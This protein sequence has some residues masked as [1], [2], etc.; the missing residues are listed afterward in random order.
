MNVVAPTLDDVFTKLGAFVA[1]I[2]PDDTAVIRGLVNR[3]SLPAA[4]TGFVAMTAI[5]QNRLRTNIDTY[6]DNGPEP[7]DPDD[8]GERNQTMGTQLTIQLDCYGADSGN[9]AAMLATLLRSEIGCDALAPVAQPLFVDGPHMAPLID[10]EKQY[11]ERWIV[12][13]QLQYNPTVSTLQQF[14]G[15]LNVDL[16]NVDERYPP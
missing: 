5:L 2:V 1:S 12:A 11:E 14:A 3:T 15:T 6:V 8:P 4:A 16:V 7:P 13:A 9:W 10:S